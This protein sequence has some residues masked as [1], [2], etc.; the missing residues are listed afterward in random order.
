MTKGWFF[1]WSIVVFL[2]LLQICTDVREIKNAIVEK[3][4][5]QLQ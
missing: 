2:L 3:K 5:E 4:L 1:A